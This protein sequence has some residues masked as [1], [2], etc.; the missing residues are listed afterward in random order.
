M[1]ERAERSVP[2]GPY[3]T[4]QQ[5]RADVTEVYEQARRSI[6]QGALV[7]ANHA[8]LMDTCHALA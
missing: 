8:R 3:E 4:E 5:A 6:R 1:S 2:G 7:E